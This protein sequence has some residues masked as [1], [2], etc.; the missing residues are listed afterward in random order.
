MSTLGY[1][2]RMQRYGDELFLLKGGKTPFVLRRTENGPTTTM[3]KFEIVGDCYV[4][5]MMSSTQENEMP[6]RKW[7]IISIL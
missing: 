5:D 6:G 4:H 2:Q 7:E 3:T 1:A